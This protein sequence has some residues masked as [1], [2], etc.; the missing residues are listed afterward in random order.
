LVSDN[1]AKL[2][3]KNLEALYNNIPD[4]LEDALGA[5][6][7][8]NEFFFRAFGKDCHI[9]PHGIFLD[10]DKQTGVLGILISLYGLH[11]SHKPFVMNPLKHLKNLPIPCH[12]WLHLLPIRS[13][14]WYLKLP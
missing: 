11:A 7:V 3:S 6:K 12:M 14:S 10:N 5:K 13:K 9:S 8:G 4:G 1:Y 2:V